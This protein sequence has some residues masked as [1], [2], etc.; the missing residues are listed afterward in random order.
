MK[1][2]FLLAQLIVMIAWLLWSTPSAVYAQAELP[3]ARNTQIVGGQPADVGEW[4]WQ[5][6]VRAG[7]Y[8]CGG[9]LVGSS[10]VVTA[11]HCVYDDKGAVFSPDSITVTLG[12]HSRLQN[13]GYE[14]VMAVTQVLPHPAYDEW[15]NENDI[16][17][18][19]LATPATLNAR[20]TPIQP[21]TT[22][23]VALATDGTMA[24][25]T[26][27]GTSGEGGSASATLMEVDVPVVSNATCNNSYG[28]ITDNM[29]CA[30]YAAGGKD[31]CQGDSGGPLVV[32]DNNGG[33]RLAGVVSFGYGCARQ[34]FYGVYTRVSQF[35]TWLAEYTSSVEPTPTP[36]PIASDVT[37]T[38]LPDQDVNF[39]YSNQSGSIA[40][41]I[42]TGAVTTPTVIHYTDYNAVLSRS[43]YFQYSG[44]A[45]TLGIE[46][47]GQV[48]TDFAFAK[49]VTIAMNYSEASVADLDES[50]FTL[51]IVD[52]DGVWSNANA[53]V[54]SH[55]LE[56]N[57][58]VMQ[59]TQTGTF[60]LG[61]T[62]HQLFL[63]MVQN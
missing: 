27:W 6:M 55:D 62:A 44:L 7:G 26:G 30:G 45:F 61:A 13:D 48:S 17:L 25:V 41:T 40:M 2:K 57:Q 14:Q 1:L 19:K 49:Q 16:A 20:V 37:V 39:S 5:A 63:P 53:A 8:L 36:A 22:A 10:W 52:A 59:V 34:D 50:T 38:A 56:H 12:D 60:A 54:I 21:L 28:T 3:A 33:W 24:Y 32:P 11:A 35:A 51:Y 23:E 18:L 46:Q 4:P 9:S 29:I 31:S 43:N 58:L 15:S 42:P 47:A